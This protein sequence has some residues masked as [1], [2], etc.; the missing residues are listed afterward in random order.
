M[1]DAAPVPDTAAF[2]RP[3][4]MADHLPPQNIEA[5][6]SLIS[7]VLIDNST[8]L[9]IVEVLAPEDFYRTA[10]QRIYQAIIDLF[11]RSEPI[12]LITLNNKLREQG[13]LEEIGGAAYLA[14]LMDTAPVAANAEHYARIVHDKACLRRLIES[15]NQIRQRCFERQG[16]VEDLLD[17]AEQSVFQIAENK[18]RKS[19]HAISELIE[20]NIDKLEERQGNKTLIT[21]VPTG[22]TDLDHLTS[23]LQASDLIILAARPSMGKTAFALNIARNAAIEANIPVAIFSLEMSK[24]QLSMRMLCAEARVDSHRLRGGFL[25]NED[26]H[27]LTHAA[28]VLSEAPIYID[29]SPDISA[30]DIRAKARRLKMEKSLGL[31]IIDY[32]QLMK[33]RSQSERRDLEI[34]DI[35][36]ALKSL[37]KELSLPVVA[38]SQLNRKLE[39]RNDKRPKLSDLRE[40]GALEQDADLV[41]F[42]YRDEVYNRDE[43]NPNRGKAEILVSK[44]RNGPT[45]DIPLAFIHAYTRFENLARDPYLADVS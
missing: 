45:G 19:F 40:S 4:P 21:G 31:V 26:W 38:L 29:D 7:A 13:H 30:L 28:S 34:S 1:T 16:S 17:F 43:N 22:F 12:D 25:S 36:R 14:R 8:L 33:A 2:D 39:E 41:T 3:M 20:H 5:E 27:N 35:S 6:E 11:T 32:L 23:G 18:T 15:A 10:H 24:E 42:I 44:H 9:E 37:A